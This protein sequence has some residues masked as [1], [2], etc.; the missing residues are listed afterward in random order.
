MAAVTG[1][2]VL[3][4]VGTPMLIF[5]YGRIPS[6]KAFAR[7]VTAR[8]MASQQGKNLRESFSRLVSIIGKGQLEVAEMS[9]SN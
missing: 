1:L 6:T 2:N 9:P 8:Q 3:A 4:A 7:L 5:R